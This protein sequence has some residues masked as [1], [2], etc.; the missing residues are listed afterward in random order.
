[1]NLNFFLNHQTQATP[2]SVTLHHTTPQYITPNHTTHQPHHTTPH[3]INHTTSHNTTPHQPHH[4]TP[5]HN[6]TPTTPHHTTPQHTTPH[7][8]TPHQPHHTTPHHTTPQH[9]TPHHTTPHHTTPHHTTPHHTTPH[10]TTPHHTTPHHTT[11]YQVHAFIMSELYNFHQLQTSVVNKK[12]SS[13]FSPA[14]KNRENLLE[15]LPDVFEKLQ[16]RN[17]LNLGDFPIL[18]A[19]HERLSSCDFEKKLKPLKQNLMDD[20]DKM[21]NFD[22]APLMA[23]I[24]CGQPI[25]PYASKPLELDKNWTLTRASSSN[26]SQHL[27]RSSQ[28][29]PVVQSATSNKTLPFFLRPPSALKTSAST[30]NTKALESDDA[31]AAVFTSGGE[32]EEKEE[33]KENQKPEEDLEVVE[34]E[35]KAGEE[36]INPEETV[37]KGSEKRKFEEAGLAQYSRPYSKASKTPLVSMVPLAP[38]NI[39]K[40]TPFA[41]GR[42]EGL[43]AGSERLSLVG[44]RNKGSTIQ[45]SQ[46]TGAYCAEDLWGIEASRRLEYGKVFLQVAGEDGKASGYNVREEF[47]KS[48]LPNAVLAKI[49]RLS[50]MDRDDCLD[51]DEFAVAMYLID[52]KLMGF[53]LPQVVPLS[54]ASRSATMPRGG[55]KQPLLLPLHL[56][57]PSKRHLFQA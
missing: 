9:T 21:L 57:P 51:E 24:L 31:G 56:I 54:D 41:P 23:I 45:S 52:M 33:G 55:F 44:S 43:N 18:K 2:P 4:T 26:L 42:Y 50:D 17:D 22:A 1:M 11:P 46:S 32:E 35:E 6:T 16:R 48:R 40:D 25:P 14:R 38:L 12:F 49:W 53:E 5:H 36:G 10:H 7:H 30:P 8:T 19:L 20:V 28:Q 29:S 47:L 39:L 37:A 3:H 15:R 34:E 27:P 13:L